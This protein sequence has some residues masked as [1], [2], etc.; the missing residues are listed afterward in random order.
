MNMEEDFDDMNCM[1]VICKQ[2]H[3]CQGDCMAHRP[4]VEV[5]FCVR[6]YDELFRGYDDAEKTAMHKVFKSGTKAEIDRYLTFIELS[7]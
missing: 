4:E 2:P 3:H 7:R 1:C 5:C 6:C